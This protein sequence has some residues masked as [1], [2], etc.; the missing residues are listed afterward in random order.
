MKKLKKCNYHMHTTRCMHAVGTDEDYVLSA[1]KGGFE[2]IGF[3]DHSP[4]KY[5]SDYVG[6]MRMRLDQFDDY[7]KSISEL[8]EKYKDQISI[9]IGLECEYFPRYMHWL[10]N[11]VKEK[12]IDY[13]V[14]GNHFHGSDEYGNYYGVACRDDRM[15]VAYI[16]D[17][18]A[19]LKTGLYSY[20]AH[21]DLFMRGRKVFNELTIEQSYRLC[22]AC[23][24]M[25]VPLGYNLEGM[26]VEERTNTSQYPD[27]RFWKIAAEVGNKAIIEFDAHDNTSLETNRFYDRAINELED[28]GIEIVEKI[29]YKW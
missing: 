19:G 15:F 18:I 9:K 3:S 20:L 29:E 26:R 27:E 25:D 14:F 24:E 7:Y 23:K 13:I 22:K 16:D 4:W 2:E 21:P 1:I 28:L 11:F 6:T 12:K 17:C 8:K 5:N 10:E